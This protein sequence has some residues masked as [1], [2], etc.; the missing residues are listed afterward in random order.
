M[1]RELIPGTQS[2]LFNELPNGQRTLF[3]G[4]PPKRCR[5]PVSV[6]QSALESIADE[7]DRREAER[8]PTRSQVDLF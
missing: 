3:N 5:L 7:I 1:Q 4:L 8:R 2:T 6:A